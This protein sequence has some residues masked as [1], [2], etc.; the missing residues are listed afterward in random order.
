MVGWMALSLACGSESTPA[1]TTAP[2]SGVVGACDVPTLS[3]CTR[4]GEGTPDVRVLAQSACE[5]QHGH[6]IA[7]ACPTAS[8][9]ATC[10]ANAAGDVTYYYSSGGTPYTSETG[11]AACAATAA[12][13]HQTTTVSAPAADAPTLQ[14]WCDAPS[15]WICDHCRDSAAHDACVATESAACLAVGYSASTRLSRPRAALER[16]M[17]D[18]QAG[19]GPR[20]ASC[21]PPP[22]APGANV[23]DTQACSETAAVWCERCSHDAWVADSEAC[24]RA[25]CVDLAASFGPGGELGRITTLGDLEARLDDARTEACARPDPVPPGE[26]PAS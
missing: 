6:F 13:A 17:T 4:Y 14:E 24:I 26:V 23:S 5:Q 25:R 11:Q 18:V 7:G 3:T 12:P 2:A 21:R 1:T 19:C 9:V 20:P 10:A 22:V 16:C 15:G 8:V